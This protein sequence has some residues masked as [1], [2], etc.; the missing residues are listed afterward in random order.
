MKRKLIIPK[1]IG[2]AKTVNALS[3]VSVIKYSSFDIIILDRKSVV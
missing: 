1:I 3:G 2:I